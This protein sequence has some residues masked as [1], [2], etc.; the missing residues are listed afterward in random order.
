M[1]ELWKKVDGL[2]RLVDWGVPALADV[3]AS[4]GYVVIHPAK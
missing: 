2:F 1:V 4:Q 3:Y